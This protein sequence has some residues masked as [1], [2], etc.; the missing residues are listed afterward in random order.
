MALGT[1]LDRLN[2]IDIPDAYSRI[3]GYHMRR[4]ITETSGTITFTIIEYDTYMSAKAR[5]DVPGQPIKT[6]DRVKIMGWRP[7]GTTIVKIMESVYNKLAEKLGIN[8]VK[9]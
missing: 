8:N 1:R 5:K 7:T 6:G 4:P 2:D 3:T 9:I